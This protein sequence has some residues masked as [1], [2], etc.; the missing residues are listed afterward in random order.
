MIIRAELNCL[1]CGYEIGEV[2]GDKP[3]RFDDLTFVPVHQ[4]D[5][6][7]FDGKG[8]VRCPR[9]SGYA[10][11]QGLTRVRVPLDPALTYELDLRP[12]RKDAHLW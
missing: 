11:P 1:N 7:V 4:G 3:L 5:R 10:I 9:C 2:E 8:R 12:T 6:L